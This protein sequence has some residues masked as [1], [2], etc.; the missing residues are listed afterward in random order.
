[1]AE[2]RTRERALA[3]IMRLLPEIRAELQ[4]EALRQLLT[5]D[6]VREVFDTA[7][8]HQFDDDRAPIVRMFRDIV[9]EAIEEI[10]EK[11]DAS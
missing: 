10:R 4:D 9:R 11:K 2:S 3:E 1:M 5:E 7:W 8:N 6:L